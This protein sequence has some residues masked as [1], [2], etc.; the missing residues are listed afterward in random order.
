M[1]RHDHHP[2]TRLSELRSGTTAEQGLDF[3][4]S[5]PPVGIEELEG[6][7]QGADLPTGH[8]FDGLLGPLGW[9]GKQFDGPDGAHP[10]VFADRRGRRFDV[11]PRV[12]PLAAA[13]RLAPLVRKSTV[14]RPTVPRP[15]AARMIRPLLPLAR[16]SQPKARLRMTQYRGVLSATMIYDALPVN[17]IFRRVDSSTL[18]GAMDLRGPYPPFLFT[19]RQD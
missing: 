6:F 18:L 7:W 2:D 16:T 10:L 8:P 13:L 1:D 17:D 5:L 12:V 11:N 14:R 9:Q 15:L 19:L 4:D 3:F